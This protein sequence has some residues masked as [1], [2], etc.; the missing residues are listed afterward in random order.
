MEEVRGS[1]GDACAGRFNCRECGVIVH[2]VVSDQNL[3]PAAA[4]HVERRKIIERARSSDASE[5]PGV[6]LIPE[7]MFHFRS[8]LFCRGSLRWRFNGR[9]DH[10]SGRRY[11]RTN[12]ARTAAHDS[13]CQQR[14]S[15]F[16]SGSPS[17]K[18]LIRFPAFSDS[19]Y[20]C[21]LRPGQPASARKSSCIAYS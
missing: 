2:D 10:W 19:V 11:L 4:A 7:T 3:L 1:D 16:Q 20:W 12:H 5:Q 15:E 14:K 18:D 21:L 9:L 17:V 6:F 8:W 13:Y